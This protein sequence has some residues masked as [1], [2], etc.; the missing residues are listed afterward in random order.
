[1]NPQFAPTPVLELVLPSNLGSGVQRPLHVHLA[2]GEMASLAGPRGSANL[3]GRRAV[4]LDTEPGEVRFLGCAW[5]ALA[6]RQALA[7]RRLIGR[8]LAGRAFI[9]TLTVVDNVLLVPRLTG[10]SSHA[11]EHHAAR[12][13]ELFGMTL[14]T[15]RPDRTPPQILQLAQWLRALVVPRRLLVLE[16]PTRHLE[17]KHLAVLNRLVDRRRRRGT[18]VLWVADPPRPPPP[19]P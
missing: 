13:E 9:S 17:G 2:P 4:G 3:W 5:R 7:R 14:P 16:N 15:T 10:H 18:A 12:L 6:P 1:M 11:I 8:V 19:P